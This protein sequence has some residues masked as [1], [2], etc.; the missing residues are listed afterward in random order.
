MDLNSI[1]QRL[2]TQAGALTGRRR[3]APAAPEL[4][5]G[6]RFP[7][8]PFKFVTRVAPGSKYSILA[9][10]DLRTWNPIAKGIAGGQVIEYVDSDA[11][12]SSYRFY[13]AQADGVF[14]AKVIG[15]ASVALPPGFSLIANP[16]VSPETVSHTFKGWP[17]GTTLN[18]FDTSLFRLTEN[19]L[20]GGKWSNPSEKLL[21]GEG[22]IFYNPTQ[23]YKTASFV[24]EV[25]QGHLAIPIP[26]GFSIRSSSVPQAGHLAD[27]LHF[28]IS[29]G[30]VI[31]LFDRERQKYVLHPYQEGKW[32]AGPPI[33]SVG[34]AFWVA[35]TAPGN[36]VRSFLIES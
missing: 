30:D 34:E 5:G 13:R 17:D 23:D 25:M 24:G 36:W 16:F 15:Y 31:H 14:S 22:A 26:S 8:G 2:G 18:R 7:Y 12:K 9:S 6:A 32:T 21:P 3:K 1:I 11:P 20:K 10:P 19:A 33:L 27:D 4:S 29:D 28:P 35:K